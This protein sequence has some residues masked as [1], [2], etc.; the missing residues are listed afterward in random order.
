MATDT[1]TTPVF[2]ES[3]FSYRSPGPIGMFI[4]FTPTCFWVLYLLL[5]LLLTKPVNTWFPDAVFFLVWL[6]PVGTVTAL[7]GWRLLRKPTMDTRIDGAGIWI[8]GCLHGWEKVHWVWGQVQSSLTDRSVTL[9]FQKESFLRFDR[10]A[11]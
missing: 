6:A 11:D 3:R 8:D 7:V 1:A 2:L 10:W 5:E 4:V 9:H